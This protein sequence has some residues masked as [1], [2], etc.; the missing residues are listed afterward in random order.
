MMYPSCCANERAYRLDHHVGHTT[1]V[2]LVDTSRENH[3]I[4]HASVLPAEVDY[5]DV[6]CSLALYSSRHFLRR[7]VDSASCDGEVRSAG[8][9]CSKF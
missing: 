7:Q 2:K 6:G 8:E 5:A 4:S 9:G 1:H 3:V